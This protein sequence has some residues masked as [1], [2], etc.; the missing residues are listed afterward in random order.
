MYSEIPDFYLASNE[1][2]LLR[3]RRKCYIIK[4]FHALHRD[5]YLLVRVSPPLEIEAGGTLTNQLAELIIATR[6]KGETLFPITKWP[7]AVYVLRSLVEINREQD[8]L[9]DGE[10]ELIGWAEISN[11]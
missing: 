11:S 6:H 8:V 2:N 9:T 4:R 5:D 10:L 1:S 7:V 3:I